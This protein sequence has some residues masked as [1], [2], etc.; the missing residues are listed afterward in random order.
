MKFNYHTHTERCGHASGS[1]R[2]YIEA[3]I[4]GGFTVLGMSDHTPYPFT[5]GHLPGIRM[6][7]ED[8]PAYFESFHKLREEYKDQ[9]EIFV[10]FETE[11]DPKSF[12][13]Y[14]SLLRDLPVDYLIQGQHFLNMDPEDPPSSKRT[15]NVQDLIRYQELICEGIE[16]GRFLYT[17]HPDLIRYT[18]PDAIYEKYMSKICETALR[19]GKPLE[20]N[21]YGYMDGR[22]YPTD[23]FYKI[24]AE[25]GCDIVLGIDAHKP[26][27]LTDT[28]LQQQALDHMK[29]LG[30]HVLTELRIPGV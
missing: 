27:M 18:G 12:S 23:R 22:H 17:A 2:D 13:K 15:D 26:S 30:L 14:E 21:F 10:G 29:E 24:A 6:E 1:D 25:V 20:Y 3:A 5:N 8:A 11:Y 9:I 16:S 19:C 7:F 4:A 28:E